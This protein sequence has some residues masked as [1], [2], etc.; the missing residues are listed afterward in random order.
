MTAD[1][2]GWGVPQ[3]PTWLRHVAWSPDGAQLAGGGDDGAL[4]VWDAANGRLLQRMAGHH[5]MIAQIAWSPDGTRLAS[6]S[7]GSAGGELFVW[8]S[9]TGRHLHTVAEHP[10]IVSA[11]A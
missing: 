8:D 4:Y 1:R 2:Q 3:F 5:S 9:Q 7:G 11:V 10:E 6:G